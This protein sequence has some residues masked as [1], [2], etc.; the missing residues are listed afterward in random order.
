MWVTETSLFSN[1]K[2]N[3]KFNIP[4][5]ML[6]AGRKSCVTVKQLHQPWG[7]IKGE[8]SSVGLSSDYHQHQV[9]THRTV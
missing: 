9:Q 7:R 8:S 2:T 6:S 3:Q 4:L 5:L 1:Q